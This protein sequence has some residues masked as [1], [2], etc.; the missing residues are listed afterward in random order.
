[1]QE[2]SII[3]YNLSPRFHFFIAADGQPE[4]G[5]V[6]VRPD[7]GVSEGTLQTR[8]HHYNTRGIQQ[9][10]VIPDPDPADTKG[11]PVTIS[12]C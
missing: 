9:N 5:D 8:R 10:L 7:G 6:R 3:K 4:A 1:M 12:E 11:K 2:T